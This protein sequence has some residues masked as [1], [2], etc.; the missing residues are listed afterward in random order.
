VSIRA[1][2]KDYVKRRTSLGLRESIS[3]LFL[4]L[5]LLR[6]HRREARKARQFWQTP[7][8]RLQLGCGPNPKQGWIN[9]DL[10]DPAANLQLDLREDWPF[11]DNSAS[12]IYSEHVFEHFEFLVEVPHFL[13]EALRVLEPG[14]VFDVVVPDTE[15]ALKAY[16]NSEASYWSW[17]TSKHWH[18][19]WCQTELDHINYHFRQRGEH[20]YAWDA[21]TL[22]RILKAAGFTSISQRDFDPILDT[23]DRRIGSLCMLARKPCIPNS[24]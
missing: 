24:T 8:I 17:S 22:G 2:I 20:K 12:Y 6:L 18:P 3:C 9:I 13:G 4:E 11:P 1:A 16:G 21:E 7:P 19:D 15:I 5:R 10:F 14:G 23:E